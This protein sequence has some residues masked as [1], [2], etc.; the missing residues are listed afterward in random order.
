MGGCV[1]LISAPFCATWSIE[2][3]S[4]VT[5]DSDCIFYFCTSCHIYTLICFPAEGS[6]HMKVLSTR[7]VTTSDL[8]GAC[9]FQ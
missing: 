7:T 2:A 6:A 9:S 3:H 4:A 1:L 8:P 5:S